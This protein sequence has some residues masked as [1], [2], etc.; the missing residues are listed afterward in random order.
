MATYIL[1]INWTEQGIKSVKESP[2]RADL[3][4][5]VATRL[6]C[7]LK[8][9]YMTIGSYD[10]VALL[11][12]PDDA[13]MAKFVLAAAATGNIRTTTLK[14]FPEASYREIIAALP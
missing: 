8:D 6:G 2:K 7:E 13:A 3:A 11:E 5:A 14:A 4:R 9:I 10:L 12:A 1:L